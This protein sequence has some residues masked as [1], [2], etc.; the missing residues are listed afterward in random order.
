MNFEENMRIKL[1]QRSV[2]LCSLVASLLDKGAKNVITQIETKMLFDVWAEVTAITE[3]LHTKEIP[4]RAGA[5]IRTKR[6]N[7]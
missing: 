5:Q 1:G 2:E 7:R 4:L 3:Q 6:R